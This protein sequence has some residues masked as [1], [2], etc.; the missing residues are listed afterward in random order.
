MLKIHKLKLYAMSIQLNSLKEC[1]LE[2]R[3]LYL[4]GC[5][6][7][8]ENFS[9]M[10]IQKP[11]GSKIGFGLKE[12]HSSLRIYNIDDSFLPMDHRRFKKTLTIRIIKKDDSFDFEW[13]F[14]HSPIVIKIPKV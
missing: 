8:I 14:K 11:D 4:P 2:I 5:F 12:D 9:V 13:E 6:P 7:F 3:N 1:F 10:E